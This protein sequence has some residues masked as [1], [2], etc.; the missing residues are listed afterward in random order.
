MQY[1]GGIIPMALAVGTTL[2]LCVIIVSFFFIL[3]YPWTVLAVVIMVLASY[4]ILLVWVVDK[5][6]TTEDFSKK[7]E[8]IIENARSTRDGTR[9]LNCQDESEDFIKFA[10]ENLGPRASRSEKSKTIKVTPPNSKRK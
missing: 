7:L 3:T 1:G 10:L 5:K 6:Q 8:K 4:M 2:G 9:L